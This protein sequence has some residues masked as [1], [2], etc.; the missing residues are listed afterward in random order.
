M[1]PFLEVRQLGCERDDRVLFRALDFDLSP[2]EI[3]QIEGPNGSGKTT[4]L[5]ALCGL[6]ADF[7]GEIHWRGVAI[8]DDRESY[9]SELL[10]AGHSVGVK[11]QLTPQENLAW[12]CGLHVTVG[13]DEVNDALEKVGLYGY[14]DVP[15]HSLSAGQQRRVALARLHLARQPLWILDEPFTAIDKSGVAALE[16]LLVNHA[17]RGGAIILTT[18]HDLAMIYPDLRRISLAAREQ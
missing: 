6:S 5:R 8:R 11:A 1:D 9:F 7:E 16:Q 17:E 10:Y 15:C 12:Y 2:G 3:L 4:M 14:E 18:H 13:D